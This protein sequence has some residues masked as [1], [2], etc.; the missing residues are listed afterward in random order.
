[1]Y[2]NLENNG[3]EYIRLVTPTP[4]LNVPVVNL[5]F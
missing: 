3:T 5:I 4:G 1:M 2:E